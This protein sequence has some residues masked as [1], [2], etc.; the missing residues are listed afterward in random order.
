MNAIPFVTLLGMSGV[1]KSHLSQIL[2]KDNWFHYSADYRIGSTYLKDAIEDNLNKQACLNPLLA[3]FIA[4]GSIRMHSHLSI[5]DLSPSSHFIGCLGNPETG[6]ILF[7]EFI[8]RQRL[9]REAEIKTTYDAIDFY[10]AMQTQQQV[11]GFI[12]DAGG[13]LCEIADSG[14][15]QALVDNG[16]IILYIRANQAIQQTIIQRAKDC[17]K[18]LYFNEAFLTEQ[19]E[20]FKDIHGLSYS[21]EFDPAAFS[22]W[23]FPKL[24]AYRQLLYEELAAKYAITIEAETINSIRDSHDFLEILQQ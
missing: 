16:G 5:N 6:G 24:I 7:K 14:A 15:I 20:I 12:N 2:A 18:P 4:S 13:S 9:H 8:R 10:K 11:P 3:P 19:V 17:P 1:G 22:C 21:A 23:I